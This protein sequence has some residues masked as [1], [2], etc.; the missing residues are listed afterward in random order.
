M[1]SAEFASLVGRMER[2]AHERQAAY[3]HR[4]FALAAPFT[5]SVNSCNTNIGQRFMRP[6]R[7][8]RSP[9]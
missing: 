5:F 8:F 3:R 4:V 7:T 9:T 2:L 6:R 1:E